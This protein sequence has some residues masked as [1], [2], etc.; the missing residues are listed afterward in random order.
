MCVLRSSTVHRVSLVFSLTHSHVG[1][2]SK[3]FPS[4]LEMLAAYFKEFI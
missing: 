1:L 3:T 2:L 4:F